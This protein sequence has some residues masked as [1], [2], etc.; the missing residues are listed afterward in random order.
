MPKM[1]CIKLL[2]MYRPVFFLSVLLLTMEAGA[3]TQRARVM[4]Y[5]VENLF[6]TQNDS[7]TADDEFTPE[8]VRHWYPKR[9]YSKI[10]NLARVILSAG[11]WELPAIVGM[12]E[13]EN[14]EVLRRL[15]SY[16]PLKTSGYK[17]VHHESPDPRGIDVALLYRP[18]VFRLLAHRAVRIA[19][20]SGRLLNTRDI[21]YAK[22]IFLNADTM[23]VFVNHWPSKYGGVAA[24]LP[25]RKRVAA[26]L[27]ALTDS[28][29]QQGPANILIMGDLNDN[30]T[31]VSVKETLGACSDTLLCPSGLVNLMIPLLKNPVAG[32]H[33]YQGQWDIIDHIIVS[34]RMLRKGA[35]LRAMPASIHA[36]D[37]LLK[38]D[39]SFTGKNLF[40]TYLGMRYEGG[41]SDH[42]PVYVD[43]E[44]RASLP[45]PQ[46]QP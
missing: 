29:R 15:I 37:F 45:L 1:R 5:N 40:R 38:K 34:D 14:V 4:F 10:N 7:L 27:R 21:L 36:P 30:P 43:I 16:S 2:D 41:F 22:G 9:F 19:D 35:P 18:E 42:L 23:H 26:V 46:G 13:V 24:S 11:E 6:D 31:D 28:I 39:A 3:Q 20:S 8:G 25:R 32:T 33:K 12:C 44:A 17:I